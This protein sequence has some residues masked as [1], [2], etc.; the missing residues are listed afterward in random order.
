MQ[1]KPVK[2]VEDFIAAV[3]HDTGYWQ[4][5][6]V[7]KQWF[8][9]QADSTKPPTPSVLRSTQAKK[10]EFELAS[11]FRL[12]AQAFGSTPKTDRLDQW[13]ILM[14]HHRVPT[15]LLDWTESP[16]AGLFF[17][18]SEFVDKPEDKIDS[19]PGV[20]VLNPYELNKLSECEFEEELNGFP[21]T[22]TPPGVQ[23][24]KIAFGTHEIAPY[25]RPKTH[26]HLT[27]T[28]YPL[29]FLPSFI[30]ARVSSQK[31]CFTIHGKD[32]SDFEVIGKKTKIIDNGFFLKYRIPKR[33]VR[34]IIGDLFDMG[35]TFSSLFPDFNNL[36]KDLKYQ[37]VFPKP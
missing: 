20:W 4:M 21:N 14:Q 15:R 12:K 17:A 13:L 11:L 30:H 26:T 32:D 22:W 31:S 28:K 7:F 8:R 36:A 33:H 23:N 27:A 5:P 19:E 24:F 18:V 10:H 29:A 3:K 37:F 16:L 34:P 2:S 1:D 6:R 25:T 35:V 9:G